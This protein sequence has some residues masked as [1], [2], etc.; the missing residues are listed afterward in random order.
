MHDE[1]HLV[2]QLI[3]VHTHT[4]ENYFSS[5]RNFLTRFMTTAATSPHLPLPLYYLHIRSARRGGKA[6]RRR[7]EVS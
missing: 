3:T 6:E 4:K 1:A 5:Q 2:N 7:G